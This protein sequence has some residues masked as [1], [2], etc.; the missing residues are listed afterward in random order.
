MLNTKYH[1]RCLYGTKQ[2]Y[3]PEYMFDVE[4]MRNH[5]D[6]EEVDTE[7]NII[8]RKDY[9]AV[10]RPMMTVPSHGIN[11]DTPVKSRGKRK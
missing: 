4:A 11:I 10:Q 9:E 2:L 8:D 7:G 5:P 6:Y 1:F 3:T